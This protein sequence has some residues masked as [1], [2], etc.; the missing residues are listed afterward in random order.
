MARRV[1]QPP[2]PVT[3][4]S[5]TLFPYSEYH[6][7][8]EQ[9]AILVPQASTL[10]FSAICAILVVMSALLGNL[11]LSLPVLILLTLNQIDLIGIMH[12]ANVHMN[13]A[14]PHAVR[15]SAWPQ[16]SPGHSRPTGISIINLVMAIGLS[17]EYLAHIASTY[18]MAEVRRGIRSTRAASV[19]LTPLRTAL[20]L[21]ARLPAGLAHAEAP[22][23]HVERGLLRGERRLHHSARRRRP[24]LRQIPRLPGVLL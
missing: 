19:R 15:C 8:Y 7:F 18:N 16:V 12:V 5:M 24:G 1:A 9:Y 13:G 4:R 22:L 2:F 11:L 23:R 17:V 10:L 20:L 21:A 14:P 6:I 3:A